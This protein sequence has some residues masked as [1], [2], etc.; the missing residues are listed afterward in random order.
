MCGSA[1]CVLFDRVKIH[2][3]LHE[4]KGGGFVT[5]SDIDQYEVMKHISV[6]RLLLEQTF[7]FIARL[8]PCLL[9]GRVIAGE[10]FCPAQPKSYPANETSRG[11]W[12]VRQDLL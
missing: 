9:R 5:E 1:H 8:V 2:S 10:L 3:S 4:G 7:Q 11:W 12:G 6:L